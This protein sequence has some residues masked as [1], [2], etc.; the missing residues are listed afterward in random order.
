LLAVRRD[1]VDMQVSR[2]IVVSAAILIIGLV[3]A[4]AFLLGRATG[5]GA[6]AKHHVQPIVRSEPVPMPK[7]VAVEPT[8]TAVSLPASE[9]SMVLADLIKADTDR[10]GMGCYC[11]FD[12][13]GKEKFVA[14]GDG[15]AILR[16]NDGREL[17][18]IDQDKLQELFDGETSLAC[19][20]AKLRITPFGEVT[21]GEDGHSSRARLRVD[22]D[23]ATKTFVGDW[24]C[25]C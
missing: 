4:V 2:T 5:S 18:E 19:G 21:P 15:V 9:P 24:G 8:P 14:G 17:C 7:P 6:V 20:A 1:Y 10:L 11:G 23:G 13:H 16:P 3:I 12:Q 25:F 22:Y